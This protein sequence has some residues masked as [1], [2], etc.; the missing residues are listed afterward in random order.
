MHR[1][2]DPQRCTG[3]GNFRR[4]EK[5]AQSGPCSPVQTRADDRIEI[6]KDDIDLDA[7]GQSMLDQIKPCHIDGPGFR[8]SE[9]RPQIEGMKP[10]LD[11]DLR[12]EELTFEFGIGFRGGEQN[13]VSGNIMRE[14]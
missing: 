7:A 6:A 13:P 8:G 14:V 4:G 3:T 2:D 9:P 5:P 11:F 10:A 1:R 12:T